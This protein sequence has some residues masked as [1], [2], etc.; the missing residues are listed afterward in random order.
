MEN[1]MKQHGKMQ[2]MMGQ[3]SMQ[4]NAMGNGG[5][6]KD[7]MKQHGRMQQMMGQN[8]EPGNTTREGGEMNDKMKQRMDKMQQRMGQN[9]GGK[10]GM[11]QMNRPTTESAVKLGESAGLA[12]D[13]IRG[14][15]QDWLNQVEAEVLSLI[16][17]NGGQIDMKVIA[18]RL[19]ISEQSTRYIVGALFQRGV[20]EL[21]Q[22]H[23]A[24]SHGEQTNQ[25]DEARTPKNETEKDKNELL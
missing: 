25:Q 14:L 13:E 7:R 22:V 5:C 4:G 16:S 3:N 10:G 9:S 1:E 17:E 2:R 12:T 6:M 23:V 21:G 18:G 24:P 8:S 20:L 11:M 15:F 19:S